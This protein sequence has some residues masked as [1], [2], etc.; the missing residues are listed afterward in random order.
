MSGANGGHWTLEQ[1]NA[2]Y[3][4]NF[5]QGAT[6]YIINVLKPQSVLEFGCGVGWYCKY[7]SDYGVNPMHGIEP[8]TMDPSNFENE[9]CEQFNFDVTRQD[10]PDG[11]QEYYDVVLSLEVLEHIPREFHTKVFDY[12]ASKEPHV[13]VFSGA[14]VGQGGHG[15]VAERPEEEWRAEWTER[16]YIFMPELTQH[17]RKV[18][19]PKNTNHIR[20]IQVFTN[21][22][23]IRK[24]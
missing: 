2:W 6:D 7:L 23:N 14:R 9:G 18:C 3:G 16:G 24:D 13:V 19:T 11:I 8:A 10:E 12:L 17:I 4:Y 20:N 15:H 5:N 22:R 21:G 1:H